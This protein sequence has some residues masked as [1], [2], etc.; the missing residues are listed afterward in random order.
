[1][2]ANAK[3]KIKIVDNSSWILKPPFDS[4]LSTAKIEL[5]GVQTTFYKDACKELKN[6]EATLDN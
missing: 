2:L 3:Q 4:T 6:F 1:M 5:L